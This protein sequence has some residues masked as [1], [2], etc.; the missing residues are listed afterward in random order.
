MT[1]DDVGAI[2]MRKTE[3]WINTYNI[4]LSYLLRCNTDVTSLLSG[5]QVK[6]VIAYVTDY[7][8]KSLLKTHTMFE[9][10]R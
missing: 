7:I 3:Q 5:T 10:I 2:T 6:A 8:T 4:V 9:T 1:V